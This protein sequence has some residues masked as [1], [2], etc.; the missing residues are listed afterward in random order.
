MQG[1]S[2]EKAV[3]L[4]NEFTEYAADMNLILAY[5]HLEDDWND[6]HKASGLIGSKAFEAE[7]KRQ[8]E[9]IQGRAG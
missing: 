6:E 2:G 9:N 5:Y 8:F 1:S 7:C 3:I 4:Q